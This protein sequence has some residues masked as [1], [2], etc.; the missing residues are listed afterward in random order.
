[1]T[2]GVGEYLYVANRDSNTVYVISTEN[3]T[4]IKDIPVGDEPVAM[5]NA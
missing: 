1:M 2:I 5:A 4:K 3:N